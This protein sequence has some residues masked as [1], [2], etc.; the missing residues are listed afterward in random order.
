MPTYKKDISYLGRDFAGLRG[1]LIE[2]AKT[3]FP[4]TY[5]D[6][7]ESAPGTMF[8]ESAAYV[9]DVLGYYIDAMFK[10]SLLPYAEEK[11]QVYNIAQFMGYTP[12]L[13]SP[14]MATVTFSQEVPA[15]TDDPT[16]PDYDY[17]LNVKATTRLFAPN[18]GVEYRLLT[19]CNFKVDQGDVVKEI[20]QTST[21]G[22]IEY[23]RLHKKVTVVSGYS[24]TETFTFGSPIKYDRITLSEENVT[25]IISVTDGDGNTWYEVPFLAQDM[26]FSEFQNIES[27]DTSLVQFDDTNPYILKRL[28]TSKRFRTYVRPDKKTEIRFGAGTLVTPDEELIPNPDNVGSNLPGSPSKLGIA[29]DPNNFTKTRAYG[30]APSNT[31][32][33]ITYA[34]DGGSKHNVRSGEI[35]SFASKIVTSL[36]STLDGSKI[37]RVN[38]SLSVVND[39]PSSGG[40]DVESI[41]EIKQNAIAYFQAQS[42]SVTKDDL[43]VRIYALPERYGNI[44]KAYVVQDEQI[45]TQPGEE[46]TFSKNQFGLNLY[47]LGY[48]NN[49][50]LTKLNDVTKKNLKIYLDRFRMITDAYNIKDAYIVNIAIKFDILTKKGYNKNE[51]LVNAINEMKNYFNI[52]RWQVNQPIVIAEVVAKLIEVEGVVGVETPSDSNPLG[53]NIVIENRYDTAKGYSGN[54][55]DLGDPSVI[56]NG[57]VYPSRDPAI[58]ELKYPDTDIIGRVV[59]DV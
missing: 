56:K 16:Q 2:F 30:E 29:F 39:E 23:Y 4:N 45:T 37:T 6:F 5:K 9:G 55:Y 28:K 3:Y 50:K 24:K 17:A 25:D 15:M 46:L 22:T 18:F 47:L 10:E 42:R 40:M 57:V 7:N 13:I 48:N 52:D 1:N 53:T 35:N 36:P 38:N 19:D 54:V 49:R 51:V 21:T 58:F 11:N 20:S 8:L 12:R 34:F 44:A 32:L 26:V 33:E 31:T 14:S 59:G 43:L 41:E 27:N